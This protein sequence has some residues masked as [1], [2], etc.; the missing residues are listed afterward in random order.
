MRPSAQSSAR[1]TRPARRRRRDRRRPTADR[2]CNA[3]PAPAGAAARL[4]SSTTSASA[5]LGTCGRRRMPRPRT[6]S[7]PAS[8]GGGGRCRPRCLPDRPRP[9]RSREPAGAAPDRIFPIRRAEQ[10]HARAI[11]DR[12]APMNLHGAG[13]WA[14][15][16]VTKRSARPCGMTLISDH[17]RMPAAGA[18]VIARSDIDAAAARICRARSAHAPAAAC[19]TTSAWFP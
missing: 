18:M 17:R 13:T 5:R 9:D 1:A 10:Q 2:T 6:S 12:A 15:H 8:A 16:A 19:G 11:S 4:P 14:A 7:R 3:V